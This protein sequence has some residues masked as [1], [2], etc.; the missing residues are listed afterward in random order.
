PHE[1]DEARRRLADGVEVVALPIDDAWL[2]DSGP[3]FVRTPNGERRGL[4]FLFNGWGGKYSPIL[5]DELIG[6]RLST[7]LSIPWPAVPLVLEGGAIVVDGS[8]TLVTTERCLL[9]PNRND[10]IARSLI[11]A[12]LQRWLGASRIVWLADGIA[13]DDETDG[14]VDNVV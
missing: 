10:G 12:A 13:E 8:G 4:H 6:S 11:E 9:N 14:H 3:I 1:A 2:R 5:N 7:H